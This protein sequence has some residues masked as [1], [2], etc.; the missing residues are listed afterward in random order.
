MN[1]EGL[2]K[3]SERV[4]WTNL[5]ALQLREGHNNLTDNDVIGILEKDNGYIEISELKRSGLENDI[6]KAI[7]YQFDF[8]GDNQAEII[9]E[10]IYFSPM[11]FHTE[12]ENPF[13]LKNR[14]F[15][16]DLGHHL[17]KIQY[18]SYRCPGYQVVST[19]RVLVMDY[20]KT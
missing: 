2:L 16:V 15:P 3:G 17:K 13:K 14:E 8:E 10:K 12:K 19:R 9:G 6:Y 11:L 20:R 5:K 4:T 7:T 18:F 1:E